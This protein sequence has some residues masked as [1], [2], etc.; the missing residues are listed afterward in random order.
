M[1]FH[2]SETS[3]DPVRPHS[4]TMSSG[5]AWPVGQPPANTPAGATGRNC[6]VRLP[7]SMRET[8]CSALPNAICGTEPRHPWAGVNGG[9]VSSVLLATR[10]LLR[11]GEKRPAT[12]VPN[13]LAHH[14]LK[15]PRECQCAVSREHNGPVEPMC[16]L[17]RLGVSELSSPDNIVHDPEGCPR[18]EAIGGL[19]AIL[20]TTSSGSAGAN[21]AR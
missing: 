10:W 3:E 13:V 19:D 17:D 8:G 20:P 7:V 9:I 2:P 12:V 18:P 11:L 21:T 15:T 16:P 5:V 1:R 14:Q 4:A 6:S